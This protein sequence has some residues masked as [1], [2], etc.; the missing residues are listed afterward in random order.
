M[1]LLSILLKILSALSLITGLLTFMLD[2]RGIEIAK[3]PPQY[4]KPVGLG[5]IVLAVVLGLLDYFSGKSATEPVARTQLNFNA[6]VESVINIETL[7]NLHLH[8]GDTPE[9]RRQKIVQAHRLLASDVLANVSSL[10]AR[11]GFAE[12]AMARDSTEQRLTAIRKRVAPALNEV[13]N[14]GYRRLISSQSHA[15]LRQAFNSRPLRQEFGAL[16]LQVLQESGADPD[17]V[18]FFYEQ[19]AQA[20]DASESLLHTM[21]ELAEYNADE[22]RDESYHARRLYLARAVLQNRSQLAY[23]AALRVLRDLEIGDETAGLLT[24]LHFLYPR[25]ILAAPELQQLL[26]Q[27]FIQAADLMKERGELAMEGERLLNQTFDDYAAIDEMLTIQTSD[28]PHQIVG[29]A[30]SLR[31]LG[32]VTEAVA[33]FARYAERFGAADPTA[34]Q[35]G[36]TAQQFTLQAQALGVEGGV[37]VSEVVANG[38][39]ARGGLQVGDIIIAYQMKVVQKPEELTAALRE[40]QQLASVEITLLRLEAK[41]LFTRRI[42][43]VRGGTLGLG[44]I[45][46]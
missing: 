31:Q 40:A 7:E 13:A 17:R 26:E 34:Q 1:D 36:Q 24:T 38:A 37:Y 5:L 14:A 16:L 39:A 21:S 46:I 41:G 32:R 2:W 9:V 27:Y 19:L 28:A 12:Q 11:L 30:I 42:L 35:Y 6:P 45:T 22:K 23:V 15:A 4:L 29:K 25:Q 43:R 8:T 33:A 18:R 20:Q 44:L 10:D 3:L